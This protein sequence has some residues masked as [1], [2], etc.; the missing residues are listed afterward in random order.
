[1][2]HFTPGLAGPPRPPLDAWVV[3]LDGAHLLAALDSAMPVLPR[4]AEV[5]AWLP[6]DDALHHLGEL[7]GRP[8]YAVHVRRDA[9]VAEPWGWTELRRLVSVLTPAGFAV[10]GRA[11]Q[12][13]EW[14][15]NHRFCGRCGSPTGPHPDGERA[16]ICRACGFGAYPRINPCVIGIVSRGDEI[17]L[18]RAHRFTNGM[19]SALAGFM[20]VGESAEETLIR[21]VREEVGVEITNIRY[22]GSQPWP[23]PSN[24]MLGFHAE[25]AGGELRLQDDEIAEAGFFRVDALPL[26]PPRGSIARALIDD[27]LRARGRHV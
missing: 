5:A 23:F 1:M 18:A 10:T 15:R 25:Y 26:I 14:A 7:D 8:A 20:E 17:L 22:F 11:A 21:E 2:N 4:Y 16:L 19:F 6:P 3:A 13:L 24:L 9:G 12:L 27:F